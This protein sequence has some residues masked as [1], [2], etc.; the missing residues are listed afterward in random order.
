MDEDET[1][2]SSTQ[3]VPNAELIKELLEMV[4]MFLHGSYWFMVISATLTKYQMPSLATATEQRGEL[5]WGSAQMILLWV[6]NVTG[7]VQLADIIQPKIGEEITAEDAV[8]KW[9]QVDKWLLK[10]LEKILEKVEGKKM[11][12]EQLM[13][14]LV[15]RQATYIS[16]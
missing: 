13:R 8:G 5:C 14:E 4:N 3:T 16:D 6:I 15:E 12:L 2:N 11:S 10:N 1:T 9:D 7:T